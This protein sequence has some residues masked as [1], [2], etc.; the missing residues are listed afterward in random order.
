MT[1]VDLGVLVAGIAAIVG[2]NWYFFVAG[3]R[4]SVARTGADGSMEVVI[5]VDGGYEPAVVEIPAR[6]PVRLVFDR[7]DRSSCAEEVVIP[8]LGI[9][10][11]LPLDRRTAVDITFPTAGRYEFMCGMSMLRGAIVAVEPRPSHD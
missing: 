1:S 4:A 9:K 7:R 6:R 10:K 2:I 8:E 5:R 11:F 3:R